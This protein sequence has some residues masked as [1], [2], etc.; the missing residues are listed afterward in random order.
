[1]AGDARPTPKRRPTGARHLRHKR[2]CHE[3]QYPGGPERVLRTRRRCPQHCTPRGLHSSRG[4]RSAPHAAV[5]L[6]R[7]GQ[8][9]GHGRALPPAL[10]HT[11]PDAGSTVASANCMHCK[12]VIPGVPCQC[13]PCGHRVPCQAV[14][15]V[16]TGCHAKCL[17]TACRC[18]HCTRRGLHSSV[19]QLHA[20]QALWSQGALWSQ[21]CHANATKPMPNADRCMLPCGGTKIMA[22]LGRGGPTLRSLRPRPRSPPHCGPWRRKRRRRRT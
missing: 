5:G 21:V 7:T 13:L 15:P 12:P 20:L 18:E 10:S 3:A 8:S 22:Q 11:V 19:C 4:G 14:C 2:T 6:P 9:L 16:V 1:M 17:P